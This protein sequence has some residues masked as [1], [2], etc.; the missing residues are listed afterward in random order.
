MEEERIIVLDEG[1]D[2]KNMANAPCCVGKP[3]NP[4]K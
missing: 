3:Q 2:T 4:T 1:I